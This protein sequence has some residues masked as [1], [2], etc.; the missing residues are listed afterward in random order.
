MANAR[1]KFNAPQFK[2]RTQVL[3]RETWR[4]AWQRGPDGHLRIVFR[5]ESH[6]H[7]AR[8]DLYKAVQAEKHGQGLD[9]ELIKAAQELE[10]VKAPDEPHVLIMRYRGNNDIY[11]A[12]QEATG[13]NIESMADVELTK[14]VD[15]S[16]KGLEKYGIK[17]T[18]AAPAGEPLVR[19]T[20]GPVDEGE[21]FR[22]DLKHLNT[23]HLPNPYAD[24]SKK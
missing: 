13:L 17:P 5:E 9:L 20:A 2:S 1:S 4:K 8:M 19:S 15:E 23:K 18:E 10:I 16:L 11:T 6:A 12:L 22:E 7:K 14:G 3:L 24:R 21:A